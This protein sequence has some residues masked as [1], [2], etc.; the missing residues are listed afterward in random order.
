MNVSVIVE[1]ESAAV[2]EVSTVCAEVVIVS[3]VDEDES[4]E[5]VEVS[6]V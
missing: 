5:V 1:D 4:A 6:T 2:V 3:V